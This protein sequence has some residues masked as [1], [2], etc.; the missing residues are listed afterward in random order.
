MSQQRP[1]IRPIVVGVDGS[2]LSV[3]T[4]RWAVEHARRTGADV[5]AVTGW[6]VPATIMIVPTYTEAD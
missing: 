5:H 6:E 1:D 4:L 2:V 3:T